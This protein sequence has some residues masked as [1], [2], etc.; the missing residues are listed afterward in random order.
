[1]TKTRGNETKIVP[2]DGNDSKSAGFASTKTRMKLKA[3]KTKLISKM[4]ANGEKKYKP[5]TKKDTI[6]KKEIKF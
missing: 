1:M 3:A 5:T 6:S 4:K 2:K